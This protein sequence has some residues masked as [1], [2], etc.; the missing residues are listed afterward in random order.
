M[1][2]V[3]LEFGV[4]RREAETYTVELR[5]SRPDSDAETRVSSRFP[6]DKIDLEALRRQ[7]FDV[8]AHGRLLGDCLFADSKLRAAFAEARAVAEVGNAAL[9]V[10]ILVGPSAPELHALF[11][12]AL[13]NPD[14][15]APLFTGERILLSR[16]L[17]SADWRPVRRRA[18][19]VL[20]GL[21]VIG[22]PTDVKSFGLAS[23]DVAAELARAKAGLEGI[24]CNELASGGRATLDGLVQQLREGCDVLYMVCHG[25]LVEGEAW[26]WLE[27]AAGKTHRVA[28][29]E[30]IQR[31]RELRNVPALVVLASRARA[32]APTRAPPTA[33]R[34][35]HSDRGSRRRA[36]RRCW[37]CRAT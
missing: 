14:D 26:L 23:L 19:A 27:D 10:R 25:A 7:K 33:G 36:F 35:R 16:Y 32:P 9:R 29:S 6:V 24:A 2:A 15:G 13:R 3:E 31:M 34:S 21:V 8:E 20:H 17:S 37:P 12:E 28:A 30:L 11:W 1:D 5:V 4:H 22:N 18:K